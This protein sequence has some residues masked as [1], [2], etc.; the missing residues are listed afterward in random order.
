M[1][2]RREVHMAFLKNSRISLK[3]Y[4]LCICFLIGFTAFGLVAR[5]TI[6]T[7]RVQGPIYNNIVQGKDLVADILPPPE[8]IIESYLMVLQ[9]LEDADNRRLQENIA[10]FN[11]LRS[12]YEERHQFWSTKLPPGKARDLLLINSYEPARKFYQTAE[13]EFFPALVARDRTKARAIAGDILKAEY[14]EHRTVINEVVKLIDEQNQAYEKTALNIVS[15]RALALIVIGSVIVAVTVGLCFF[16][17]RLITRPLKSA[18]DIALTIANGDLTK[19]AESTCKDE[20]GILLTAMN[21]M[22]EKLRQL[23]INIKTTSEGV[24]SG[25]DHLNA[26]V[27]EITKVM[28]EQSNRSVQIASSA[29]EMS[30]TVA[31]IAK[32]VTGIANSATDTAG[33]AKLGAEVVGKSVTESRVIVDKVTH[34]SSIIRTLGDRSRQIGEIVRVINDIA[35]QTNLLALNAAIEAAR[36]GEQGRGFAVVAD[37][38]RKLAELTARATSEISDT[39][40]SIQGEVDSAVKSMEMTSFQVQEGLRFSEEAGKQLDR[41][42]DSVS[43]LQL[44]IQHIASASEEMSVASETISED[45]QSVAGSANEVSSG[46]RRIAKSS[47]ELANL[48]GRLKLA[49]DN[50]RV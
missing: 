31:D 22:A 46:T 2:L 15:S 41:I 17:I 25:S 36:A 39:I 28:G 18:V 20:I 43:N 33:I 27:E 16:I 21:K 13:K 7:L 3:L 1:L 9:A 44:M 29:T 5:D 32:N 8:Y 50:F 38:V 30:Q 26:S 6:D 40:G 19:C 37:E 14:E 35:D 48:A 11:K 49:V 23:I 42:V 47:F 45:I 24:A 10:R 4:L 34:S 12:E